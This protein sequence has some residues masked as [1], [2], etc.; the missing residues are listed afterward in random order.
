VLPAKVD[1]KLATVTMNNVWLVPDLVHTLISVK[2]LQQKKCWAIIYGDNITYHD[3][4]NEQLFRARD[5]PQGYVI[6][7]KLLPA[8]NPIGFAYAARQSAET[9]ALW[10]A[11]LGHASFNVLAKMMKDGHITGMNMSY[12]SFAD[13]KPTD[14]PACI[15]AKHARA[16][17]HPSDTTT[18]RCLELVHTDLCGPYPVVSLGGGQYV[19][20]ILDD[21]S[22]FSAIR[23]LKT[24][25]EA[26][27]MLM[28]VL[29]Q[30]ETITSQKVHIV[31]S[32]CGGEYINEVLQEYFASKGI[33]HQQTIPYCH[34]QNG[35]AERL[36][37]TLNNAVRALLIG[38]SH[39][40][41][42]LW[43]EAMSHACF[44]RNLLLQE[45]LE[46]TPYKLFHGTTPDVSHLRVFG[47]LVY[48]RIP[49]ELRQKLD[50]KS[51]AGYYLSPEPNAKGCRILVRSKTGHYL[52]GT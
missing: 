27:F 18:V 35:K 4:F 48:Y 10:H 24:K 33:I 3:K 5:M 21:H 44:L 34:E 12:R 32:D 14:C 42:S 2:A 29:N 13:S 11:R 52:S 8:V 6:T 41:K 51:A 16:P 37:R 19:M 49:D 47:C 9:A 1:S 22:R 46:S 23:I 45:K 15:Q 43:A 20:T 31:R 36:N 17:Y 38:A 28:E 25:A 26:K 30:W 39:L 7:W 50:P 40:P